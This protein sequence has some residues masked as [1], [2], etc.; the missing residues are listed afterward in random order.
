[1]ALGTF[2]MVDVGLALA[3]V[4]VLS[5]LLYVYVGNFRHL[6]SAFSLG[7]IVFAGLFVL[8]NLAAVYFYVV[9]SESYG[10]GVALPM[11]ALN[12]AE[13]VGFATLFIVSWR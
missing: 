9:L 4:A 1:M 5:G 8:E 13:L 10:A 2:W 7:L 12:A 6:R 3:S 11:L